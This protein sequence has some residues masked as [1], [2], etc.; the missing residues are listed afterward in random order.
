MHTRDIVKRLGSISKADLIDF[1]K[2]YLILD[3]DSTAITDCKKLSV[4][5]FAD[6]VNT[7]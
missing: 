2:T 4:Y 3:S 6:T 7:T 1:Y 5:V